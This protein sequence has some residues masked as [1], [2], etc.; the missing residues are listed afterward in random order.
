[1]E[2]GLTMERSLAAYRVMLLTRLLDSKALGLHNQGK[3]GSYTSSAGHEAIHVGSVY[4]IDTRDWIFPYYRDQGVLL[5]RGV[6]VEQ[7]LNRYFGNASDAML[8]RDLPNLYSFRERRIFSIAA[9]IASNLQISVGFAMAAKMRGE[10]IVT[11]SYFGDGATSSSEFHTALNFAGV[12]GA[13]CIFICENNQYAISVPFK[14]QTASQN[15]AIKARA[16]GIVGY[17]IDGNDFFAVQAA[18]SAARERALKGEGSTLLECATYRHSAHSTADEWK[19]YRTQEELEEWKKR[20]PVKLMKDY[21]IAKSIMTVDSETKLQDE[22]QAEIVAAI[23]T[24]EN[25]PA[26]PEE[27]L[28]TDVYANPTLG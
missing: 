26:P 20:D 18:V 15:V 6:S 28:F 1:M 21:L 10:N 16:Y 2:D 13:P 19:R 3:I 27:S 24:T 17:A 22:V 9:P 12:Y 23:K 8:G 4:G 7:L 25:I 11:I 14:R 5:A